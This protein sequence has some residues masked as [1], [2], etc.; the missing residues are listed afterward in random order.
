MDEH[1]VAVSVHDLTKK[2]GAGP[3]AIESLKDL[4]FEI[5][6]GKVCVLLGPNGSGK[7]TLLKFLA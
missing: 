1:P 7:T 2:Y 3:T 5:P 4:S 6:L